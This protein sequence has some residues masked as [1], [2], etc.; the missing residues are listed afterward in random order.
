VISCALSYWYPEQ[1]VDPSAGPH[2]RIA[3]YT[4]RDAYDLLAERLQLIADRLGDS[5]HASRVLVDSNDHVDREAAV[6]SGIGFYGKHTNVITKQHGSWV[7]LGTIVTSCELAPTESMRPGCGSCT[8]C[9]DA[10]PTDAIVDDGVLDT[11]RCIT[12]WTQS[13]HD[14]PVDIRESMADMVYGCDICQDVCPW[15]RGTEKR[16]ANEEPVSGSVALADWLSASDED[17][18]ARYERF[19]IP[20]RQVRFLRRNALVALGNSKD[21]RAFG[22]IAPFLDHEDQLLA[23]HAS[24]AD[25]RLR[26]VLAGGA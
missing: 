1:H 17:L 11:R 18:D 14:I 12:Y 23:E 24:W 4:R 19:F 20:R 8:A 2:G 10:C 15:N 9:I 16:R 6:R 3:R 26:D 25:S 21:P 22:L 13:R 5:G 7:V